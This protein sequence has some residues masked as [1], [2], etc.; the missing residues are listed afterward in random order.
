[1]RDPRMAYSLA[2]TIQSRTPFE[3]YRNTMPGVLLQF[4]GSSARP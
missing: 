2:D 3:L 4:P 1:M